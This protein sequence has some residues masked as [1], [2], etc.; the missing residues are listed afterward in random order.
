MPVDELRE[1]KLKCMK[2]QYELQE[3]QKYYKLLKAFQLEKQLGLPN[4]IPIVINGEKYTHNRPIS[5]TT[6]LSVKSFT[7]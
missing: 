7:K 6:I 2:Q 3:I 5:Q 1:W 4:N